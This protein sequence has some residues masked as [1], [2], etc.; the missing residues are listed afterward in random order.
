MVSGKGMSRRTIL[1]CTMAIALERSKLEKFGGVSPFQSRTFDRLGAEN[2]DREAERSRLK[3]YN[4][5]Y[6]AASISKTVITL[7]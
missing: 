7:I 2:G 4:I 3:G 1:M 5:R 6:I